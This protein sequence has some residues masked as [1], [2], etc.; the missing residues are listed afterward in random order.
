MGG[1]AGTLIAPSILSADFA[2]MGAEC[3]AV[4]EAG[5][6]LLHLDVMDGHFVPNLTMGPAL[7]A[8]LRR[9]LPDACL[10]VHM[11]VRDPLL[12][13]RAFADAGANNYTFHIEVVSDPAEV[14]GEIR[15]AGMT[16]GLAINPPTDVEKILPYVEA[17]D[18]VLIMSVNPGFSG[19]AFIGDVLEKARRIKPLLRPT[20]RL[21]IDGGVNTRSAPA[22]REA[23]CDVL[24][25]ASA[26]FGAKSRGDY[27][28]IIAEL[29]G[30]KSEDRGQKTEVR[31]RKSEVRSQSSPASDL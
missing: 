12:L 4:L 29:R 18:L 15:R 31:S 27:P 7:C 13:M 9:R 1:G 22:C 11:M 6:D 24:V 19:Q 5:A 8:S 3:E 20:Q 28:R 21:E 16:A 14:A 26:I 30:Q 17:V 2:D 23:G 25:A 10:D